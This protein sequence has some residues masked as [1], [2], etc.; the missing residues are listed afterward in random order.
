MR[1]SESDRDSVYVKYSEGSTLFCSHDSLMFSSCSLLAPAFSSA[2]PRL[3]AQ[4][5]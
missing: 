3:A 4:C 2:L 5:A 1:Y